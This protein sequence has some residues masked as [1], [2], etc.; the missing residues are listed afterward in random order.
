MAYTCTECERDVD[1]IY[2]EWMTRE[3]NGQPVDLIGDDE[4]LCRSC[5]YNRE[6]TRTLA[7]IEEERERELA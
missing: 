5:T 3:E 2:N 7:E 4:A 1:T 6:G